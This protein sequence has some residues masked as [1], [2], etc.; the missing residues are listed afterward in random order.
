MR[1]VVVLLTALFAPG[2][3]AADESFTG[4]W[5]RNCGDAFGL[6]IKPATDDQFSVSFCGP[7][8]C[9]EPGTYR[10]NTTL[11]D[12][13]AYQVIDSTHIKVRGQDGWSDYSKCT[14]EIN[15][16]LQ[17]KDCVRGSATTASNAQGAKCKS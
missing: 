3:S 2:V 1:V 10:P 14:I 8:G 12:D 5:K 15:P 17:Y 16:K 4:F 6:Q 7:G 9:F 11:K 13:P